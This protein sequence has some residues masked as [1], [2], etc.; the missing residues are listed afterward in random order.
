MGASGP[1]KSAKPAQSSPN[2]TN[3]PNTITLK[4]SGAA[5]TVN[6]QTAHHPNHHDTATQAAHNNTADAARNRAK[7]ASTPNGKPKNND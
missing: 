1:S 2:A 4:E 3:T 5:N 6:D 7:Y